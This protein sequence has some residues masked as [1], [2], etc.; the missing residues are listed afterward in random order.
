M[1]YTRLTKNYFTVY[2]GG[3][4]KNI[5]I[6]KKL[7]LLVKTIKETEKIYMQNLAEKICISNFKTFKFP[8]LKINETG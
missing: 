3:S 7:Y 8:V 5:E 1:Y 4:K 2:Q 6:F